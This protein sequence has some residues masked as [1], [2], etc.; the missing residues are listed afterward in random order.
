MGTRRWIA[1][2]VVFGSTCTLG[3]APQTWDFRDGKWVQVNAPATRP[4]DAQ[5]SDPPKNDAT[6]DRAEELLQ[7][8]R[9]KQARKILIRWLKNPDNR[10]SPHWDRALFLTSEAFY[11]YGDRIKS[12]YYLDELLDECPDS[13]LYYASLERQYEIADKFLKGYKRRFMY[14]PM[15]GGQE[16]AIEMLFRI[17]Q[18]S[19]GSP[20]AEKA[21]LRTADYY[22]A[23]A[24]FDLAADA[25][26]AYERAFP[27]S[28]LIARV[29]LRR[30]FS[31]L[32][33][34][35][36]LRFDATPAIDARAQFVDI[37]REYPELASDENLGAV[38]ERIDATFAQKVL[39]TADFYH[40]THEPVAAVY[41]YRF[42]IRTFPNTAEAETARAKLETMPRWAMDT[43]EP[44][45]GHGYAPTT[46]PV[47]GVETR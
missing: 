16:E 38:I 47:P 6:L 44:A 32:A 1:I 8:H 28:P 33:Q 40:R 23:D 18:R 35:R 19:P 10:N 37:V 27:R 9:D 3:A 4:T 43:P 2:G 45:A 31:N 26:Q 36:G 7:Q 14:I 34:V 15:F 46:S 41:N 25:Y 11:Q 5:A 12:Y 20:M 39:E 13:R 22:F 24:Q 29:K 17:Q 21:L 30:A 42:V